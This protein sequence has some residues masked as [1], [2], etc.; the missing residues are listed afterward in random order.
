VAPGLG[1][2][3]LDPVNDLPVPLAELVVQPLSRGSQPHDP[4]GAV[5]QRRAD[6]AFLLLDRLA[7]PRRGHMQAVGGSSE[8]E[9]LRQGQE[10]L[11]IPQLHR[12]L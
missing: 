12:Y 6:P 8:V 9:F 3:R 7:D 11:D 2:D 1:G 5:E 4:G 10:D